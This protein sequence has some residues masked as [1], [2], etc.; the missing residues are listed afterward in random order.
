MIAGVAS[1]RWRYCCAEPIISIED[2]NVQ[3]LC[4]SR[5]W[6]QLDRVRLIRS[7][8]GNFR[9]RVMQLGV[10]DHQGKNCIYMLVKVLIPI[11]CS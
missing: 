1:F 6:L 7:W 11:L 4:S 3:P 2:E 10:F 5:P 8:L 9:S